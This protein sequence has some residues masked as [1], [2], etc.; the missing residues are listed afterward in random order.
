AAALLLLAPL[1]PARAQEAYEGAVRRDE[2]PKE[3]PQP[4]MTRAPQLLRSVEP[5][6]PPE[7]A[8][9]KVSGD[10]T[11]EIEIAA[12]GTV[13]DARVVTPAGHGFDEAALAAVRA[14]TF[15][16]AEVDGK[17]APVRIQYTQHF[18]F[19]EPKAPAA[20]PPRPITFKGKVLERGTRKPLT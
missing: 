10:V 3:P 19:E 16:P 5:A 7:A 2:K 12:D 20:P 6:F 17:P 11:L 8:A 18:V 13:S 15:S 1:A 4:Q 9:G 14:F